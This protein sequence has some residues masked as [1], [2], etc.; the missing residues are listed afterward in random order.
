[1]K[2]LLALLEVKKLIAILFSITFMI[3]ALKGRISAEQF[4]VVFSMVVSFYFGQ[5][6]ARASIQENK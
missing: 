3:L 1:M 2:K 6:A 5:S 4:I